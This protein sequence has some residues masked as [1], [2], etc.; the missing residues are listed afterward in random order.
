MIAIDLFAGVG[1]LS[2]GASRA[3]FSVKAAVEI[4]KFAIETH[5]LNFPNA[6]HL[7]EDVGLLTGRGLLDTIS[8]SNLD[9]LIGGPPCQGFSSIGKGEP[10]DT[11]NQLYI[12]FFRLVNELKPTCFLAENV[13][14]I[15]NE[16]YDHI[17][18]EAFSLIKDDYFILKP[19]R[20]KASEYGAATIRT[21]IFFI[22]YRKELGKNLLNES[23]FIAPENIPLIRVKDA[24]YGLPQ[25]IDSEWQ[26]EH[27]GWQPIVKGKSGYFYD[28]LWGG[29][30]NGIGDKESIEKLENN[31]VSGFLGTRH[32][33]DVLNRYGSLKFGSMDKI[34]KS[35]RLDPDGFC[36]TL[37]AGTGS[38]RGSYQAVRPIHPTESRVITPREAARLQG[39]PD[40][41]RFHSTK[42]HSFRQIG[43]SVSPIVAEQMILPLA[44]LCECIK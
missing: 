11:R 13:P 19:I 41:F 23:D 34:S 28:R 12:H 43:N 6:V 44:R 22:G 20:V 21:R 31:I 5:A 16:K 40:W 36:P 30:P 9:C 14:G 7:K 4:D 39:F 24:L 8:E 1:G 33:S 35:T 32:S 2:L 37:R 42:W 25:F 27:Q 15:M 18:E 17:R 3:G 10:T 29:I 26:L 38:D